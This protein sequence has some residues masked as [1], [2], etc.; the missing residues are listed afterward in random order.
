LLVTVLLIIVFGTTIFLTSTLLSQ[1]VAS[2]EFYVGVEYAYSIT[3]G[4]EAS[5]V[6]TL[7]DKVNNYTNLFVIGSVTLTFNRT[8]LDEACDY[9][10]NSKLNLIVLFTSSYM[11]NFSIFDWMQDAKVKYG[12][13]F[14]GIY[15]FDEPGG[16]QLDNGTFQLIQNGST[17]GEVAQ[18]YVWNVSGIVNFYLDK[19]PGVF[20]SDYGLYWFDYKSN[21]STVFA[22][23]VGNQS[24]PRIVALDRGASQTFNKDWGVIINWKYNQAPYLESR[25]E[26]F[27]DLALAY[28]AGAKYAVV[29]SYPAITP[30][31]TLTEQHFKALQQFWDTLH[32]NPDSF[33]SSN[34]QVAY[35]VP[36][37]YGFGFRSA[38]D[39][40]WG[41]FPADELSSKIYDDVNT[42]IAKYDSH[43]DILYYEPE[44]INPLLKNYSEV[45]YWNQTVP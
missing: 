30:Y 19:A 17:Y 34:S 2:R 13:K 43:L 5:E 39:T 3:A 41:L 38:E 6:K 25:D 21:Y 4:H 8:A 14:L 22:E 9:I 12:N 10:V 33:G 16:N 42:L 1:Q 27:S 15:R 37:D 29:F 40:I 35:V 44:L 31:G 36:K 26:M 28:S 24:R 7:V 32:S 23:F 18:N 11:Y 45:F 20:T